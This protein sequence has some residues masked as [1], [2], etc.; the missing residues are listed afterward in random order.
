MTWFF[1]GSKLSAVAVPLVSTVLVSGAL[2]DSST[3]L[4]IDGGYVKSSNGV[5]LWFEVPE[6]MRMIGPHNRQES[7]LDDTINMTIVGFVA[8]DT[9]LV[10][11][12]ERG[13]E[14]AEPVDY[15]RFDTQTFEGIE[16][17][18]DNG[19]SEI[20]QE[21]ISA[22]TELNIVVENGFDPLP[23]VYVEQ[24]RATSPRG[25]AETIVTYAKRI[26]SCE[27]VDDDYRAA[28][29][30]EADERINAARPK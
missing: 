12:A 25:N 17:I 28:F 22:I 30:Q 14:G 11:V 8:G 19:C 27:I 3:Y 26:D 21:D 29:T 13:E 5:D 24:Y 10:I 9:A 6:G 7:F 4:E 18:S 15:S 1:Q 23:A 16:F 20:S 2:A